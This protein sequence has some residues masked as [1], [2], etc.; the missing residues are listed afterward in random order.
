MANEMV[1]SVLTPDRV[2][3]IA[4]VTRAIFA[5]Q[6]NISAISETVLQGYFTIIAT[7]TLPDACT[8]EQ[9]QRAIEA[10]GR[11]GE[12]AV[13]VRLR[14]PAGGAHA[15]ASSGDTFIMT[16]SGAD[17]PGFL[18]RISAFLASRGI[19]IADLTAHT[20]HERF[21]VMAELVLPP[22]EDVRQVQIDLEALLPAADRLVTLQH[23]N[24]FAATN[25]VAFRHVKRSTP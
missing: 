9:L 7:A 14:Q 5:A 24:V 21:L 16:V 2:G 12:L 20:E 17:Q 13:L 22:G 8:P 25:E 1:I 23:V 3:L 4:G 11:A 15:V 6:G 19:N 10:T 18:A